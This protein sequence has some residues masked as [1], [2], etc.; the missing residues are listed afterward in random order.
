ME[1]K[2]NQSKLKSK[3]VKLGRRADEQYSETWIARN[4]A[5]MRSA[6]ERALELKADLRE[7]LTQL[8]KVSGRDL[9][10]KTVRLVESTLLRL[11]KFSKKFTDYL[12]A[13]SLQEC[14]LELETEF[15]ALSRSKDTIRW[16]S[17]LAESQA[18]EDR[19]NA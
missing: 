5:T 17:R 15:A 1:S 6:S 13:P 4:A 14:L 12:D 19:A 2:M 8:N 3:L 18:E 10:P 16:I 9:R 11:L 7:L